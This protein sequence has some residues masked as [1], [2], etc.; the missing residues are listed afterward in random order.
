[1][2]EFDMMIENYLWKKKGLIYKPS[3]ENEWW[4]SAA[5]A[6]A[7]VMYDENT[8]RIYLGA[9][10]KNK[11]SR[12][13]YIDVD[14]NNPKIVK[15]I[16]NDIILDIGKDGC[17]DDN[18]VFPAHVYKN[19]DGR[20]FL[21]YTGFQKLEKIPFS[22]FSGLAISYDNGNTFERV[23]NAPVIDRADEG[24]YTRAGL[25]TVFADGVF[26]C[27]YSVGSDWYYIAGKNRPIYEV[28]YIES[29]NGID[30]PKRGAR[31]VSVDPHTE[32][33]LGRPQIVYIKNK[34]FVFYTRRTVD[35]KYSMGCAFF[36]GKNE[37]KRCD[38]WLTTIKHG[39]DGEFDS[40]M[41]YFPAVIDTGKKI[42][43]FYC[44]N[45]YGVEGFGFAELE[46][47]NAI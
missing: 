10:D 46:K 24:L 29:A 20:I 43:L 15:K 23:S 32:H 39:S 4:V 6:P 38:E 40:E 14:A 1:M 33:G 37:W 7:P 19:H 28:N 44:G 30:F 13:S 9:W 22:N 12:I 5:M 34:L 31:I 11:I 27:C 16:S 42:F 18:G 3:N 25:S 17:F 2:I 47:K 21:Y 45:G 8:I 26:K 41:V 36:D 35:Y